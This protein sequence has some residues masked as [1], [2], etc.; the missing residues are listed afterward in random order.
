[1]GETVT[2]KAQDKRA[3]K[4]AVF[5]QVAR[6]SKAFASPKRLELIALLTQGPKPVEELA[7]ETGISMKLASAHLRELRHACLV[8]T[9]RQGKHIVY[10]LA[11]EDVARIWV[12]MHTLA[13]ARLEELQ[14]VVSSLGESEGEWRSETRRDLVRKAKAGD[15]VLLDV[16]PQHEFAHS[17]HPHARSIPHDELKAR[18]EE[19]PPD[20][21]IVAYCRGPYCLFARDAV[22][23]LKRRGFEASQLREGTAEWAA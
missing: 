6:I 12:R 3:I 7:E 18:L 20:R 14:Q 8:E 4:D 1:V 15:V 16:R 19:L 21:P 2:T 11:N 17:H 13:E 5:E 10:R 22:E 9:E 23:L